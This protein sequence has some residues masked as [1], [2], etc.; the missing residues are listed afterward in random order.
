[1][2]MRVL[3]IQGILLFGFC[4]ITTNTFAKDTFQITL[5]T[6]T[7]TV[8]RGYDSV[9][10]A[11]DDLGDEGFSSLTDSYTS[12]SAASAVLDFR[13]LRTEVSYSGNST[14]LI[15]KIPSLGINK[16][17]NG[18][19]RDDSQE[20]LEEYL[21][22]NGDGL[23]T[24]MLGSLVAETP[25]DPV[26][27]N[28][29]SFSAQMVSNSFA[30]GAAGFHQSDESVVFNSTGIGLA[31][32]HF[33]AGDYE[34]DT[35][36]LPL[37]Y[38]IHFDNPGYQLRFDLPLN[39]I[40]VGGSEAYGTALGAS[41]RVPLT[42]SWSL[43]PGLR[44]GA[45]GS[46]DMASAAVVYA[47]TLTSNYRIPFRLFELNIANMVGTVNTVSI[48]AGDYEIDYDLRNT[49]FKNGF[50]IE[51]ETPPMLLM[52]LP[53][54]LQFSVAHTLITGDD[55]FIDDYWDFSLSW[56]AHKQANNH[57]IWSHL[58]LGG[59]L[60]VGNHDYIGGRL[61]LGYTF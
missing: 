21:K 28:P 25:V 50:S 58:R 30:A 27:G 52:D 8:S 41:L 40:S 48:E 7:T 9:E 36:T 19:T 49:V 45:T 57:G 46:I 18:A 6:P 55:V 4:F 51:A 2:K 59:T 33:E 53:T 42:D 39:Y 23:V 11:I 10:D 56:G 29:A 13:G 54:S 38:T 43:T 44:V 5:T 15:F 1:M 32:G 60:T 16:S 34:Q 37:S 47:G 61:N 22:E 14:E 20:M 3:S 31:T 26:A 24:R 35:L 12:T 17:F